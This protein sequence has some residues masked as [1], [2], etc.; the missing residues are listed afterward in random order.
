M[1][2]R[3]ANV[4]Q[5]FHEQV[6]TTERYVIPYISKVKPIAAQMRVLEI[7]CGE[8]GNLLPFLQM[9]CEVTGNDIM[10]GRIANAHK[11]LKEQQYTGRLELISE[12]IYNCDHRLGLFDIIIMRDVIEHIHNQERFMAFVKQFMAEDAVFFLAFP[13]WYNPFGGHQQICKSR[14]LSKLPFFHLL[15]ATLYRAVLRLFGESQKT[16][17]DLLEIKQTGISIERFERIAMKENYSI[18]RKTLYFINPN[19]EAK[20]GMK[21]RTQWAFVSAIPFVRNFFVTAGY[22]AL[23][24]KR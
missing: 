11:Y 10:P 6:T 23:Q 2:T 5:Y 4:S 20:F 24:H 17:D 13:P 7:G 1:Q 8:G 22:Y 9:D 3:H 21:P 16:I 15:P 18:A 14:V 12:D 19:Y